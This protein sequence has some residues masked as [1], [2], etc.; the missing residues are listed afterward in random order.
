MIICPAKRAAWR[1]SNHRPNAEELAT[2]NAATRLRRHSNGRRATTRGQREAAAALKSP[3]LPKLK[4][5][6]TGRHLVCH[7]QPRA[8][9]AAAG[10]CGRLGQSQVPSWTARL[11]GRR[12]C[13][14]CKKWW[15]WLLGEAAGEHGAPGR[16]LVPRP[17]AAPPARLASLERSAVEAPQ[18]P[19]QPVHDSHWSI[20]VWFGCCPQLEEHALQLLR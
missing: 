6:G 2:M 5:S 1:P 12:W 19:T 10:G 14:R 4:L 15:Q 17:L 13:R 20:R 7:A 11:W 9:C 16:P 18:I 8:T 3:C